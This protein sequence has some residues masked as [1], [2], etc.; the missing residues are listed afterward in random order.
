MR[1]SS[2]SPWLS[3][4]LLL[5]TTATA[6]DSIS[7]TTY[8][9]TA[10]TPEPSTFCSVNTRSQ[11]PPN[12]CLPM[13]SDSTFIKTFDATSPSCQGMLHTLFKIVWKICRS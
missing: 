7:F 8:N 9:C 2:P 6:Y 4:L 12:Q 13:W 5:S 10:C 11:L 3:S 1:P